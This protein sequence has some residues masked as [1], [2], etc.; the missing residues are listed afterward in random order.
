MHGAIA[1]A[2]MFYVQQWFTGSQLRVVREDNILTSSPTY[3]TSAL[4][5]LAFRSF[6]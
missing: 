3:N 2:P 1:G 6:T 4:L 5:N